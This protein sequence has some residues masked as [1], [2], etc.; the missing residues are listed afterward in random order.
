MERSHVAGWRPVVVAPF[1]SSWGWAGQAA[2]SRRVET[3]MQRHQSPWQLVSGAA[4]KLLLVVE[5]RQLVALRML[6]ALL[7]AAV[8]ETGASAG[9]LGNS[10]TRLG[11]LLSSW[12]TWLGSIPWTTA[13][14]GSLCYVCT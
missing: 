13:Q 6:M 3:G 14:R 5:L 11:D 1:F 10:S 2:V 9:T 8:V 7:L 4:G 12:G